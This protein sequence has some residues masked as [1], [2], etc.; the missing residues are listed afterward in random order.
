MFSLHDSRLG[1][2]CPEWQ[3]EEFTQLPEHVRHK[4]IQLPSDT[5]QR[6]RLPSDDMAPTPFPDRA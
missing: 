6:E 4:P 5:R 1:I 2:N 3:P